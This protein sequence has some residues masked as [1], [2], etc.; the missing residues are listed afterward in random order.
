MSE[1]DG[2]RDDGF[3]ADVKSIQFRSG[4]RTADPKIKVIKMIRNMYRV[5]RGGGGGYMGLC[6]FLEFR[7][8]ALI[9]ETRND[10]LSW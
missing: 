8:F 1:A 6:T 5:H 2:V 9:L 10:P 3:L 7:V 4:L